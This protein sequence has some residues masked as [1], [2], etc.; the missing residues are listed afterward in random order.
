MRVRV[1]VRVWVR[2]RR[3]RSRASVWLPL[4]LGMTGLQRPSDPPPS[5]TTTAQPHLGPVAVAS[6]SRL[7]QDSR[8]GSPRSL[9][10]AHEC[11]RS[12]TSQCSWSAWFGFGLGYGGLR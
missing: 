7:K 11:M 4:G 3:A 6:G 12:L 5:T 8:Y 2:A 10:Y 9:L 1:R